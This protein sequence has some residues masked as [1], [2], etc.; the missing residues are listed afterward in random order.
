L[1][2]L[3]HRCHFPC[4]LIREVNEVSGGFAG[5]PREGREGEVT[6]WDDE[7]I[8]LDFGDAKDAF[9]WCE[10]VD[11]GG[12]GWVGGWFYQVQFWAVE[13]VDEEVAVGTGGDGLDR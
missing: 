5:L 12:G 2:D 8:M 9:V 13:E 3:R 4:R 1:R 7:F 11:E 10:G 6:G